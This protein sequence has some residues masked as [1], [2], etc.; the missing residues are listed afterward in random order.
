MPGYMVHRQYVSERSYEA[1]K[2]CPL[3]LLLLDGSQHN[4]EPLSERHRVRIPI[5]GITFGLHEKA[6]CRAEF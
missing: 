4:L 1:S 3:V 5:A 6:G 2:G